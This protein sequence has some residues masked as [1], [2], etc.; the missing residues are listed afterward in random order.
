MNY[1]DNDFTISQ[2]FVACALESIVLPEL[3]ALTSLVPI[4][5]QQDTINTTLF[6]A[7]NPDLAVDSI[8]SD[9]LV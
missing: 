1:F 5:P 7:I 4:E 2:T 9:L 6:Y 3:P 8:P